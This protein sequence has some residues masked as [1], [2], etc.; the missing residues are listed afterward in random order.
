MV[1]HGAGVSSDIF[2]TD[3]IETNLLEYLFAAGYD[4]WLLDFR[5][6]I[7]LPSAALP[8]TAD[9]VAKFDHADAVAEI[10]RLTGAQT[11]QVVAHC[12]GAS[13]FTMALLAGLTGVRSAVLSQV[14]THLFVKALG[15]IKAGLHL[16]GVLE[17][18]GVRT[19]TAYRDAHADWPQRLL[20]DALRFYPIPHGEHCDSAVCHRIS[21]MYALLYEHAQ[22][23]AGLHDNMHELFGVANLKVFEHLA[24]MARRGHVVTADGADD[25]LPHLDRMAIPIAFIHGAENQCF[26]PASTETTFNLLCAR[27]GAAL[28]ERHVIPGY[29]HIDCIFGKNAVNDV[30]PHIL[31]H[32]EKTC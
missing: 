6:S 9:D 14:S 30:Y 7:A 22:L 4:V 5:V 15:K 29:G 27:N 3:L 17:A 20:D 26:V 24:L 32:L 16:P 13:T 21:F 23:N 31:R 10:R 11:I 18:M 12:Y 2:S 8:S 28:Y 19:M 25:Y 1:I